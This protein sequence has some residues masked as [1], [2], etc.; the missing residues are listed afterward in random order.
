M[1]K[2]LKDN[3]NNMIMKGFNI[4]DFI[5]AN[6]RLSV[7]GT[8]RFLKKERFLPMAEEIET[9]EKVLDTSKVDFMG[10]FEKHNTALIV[11]KN[12]LGDVLS[13]KQGNLNDML[14][15][16][17]E[18]K[19]N[20][21]KIIMI[22]DNK[23][24]LNLITKS[25][26]CFAED[27]RANVDK[28]FDE[29]IWS[30]GFQAYSSNNGMDNARKIMENNNIEISCSNKEIGP[31]GIYVK[32]TCLCVSKSDLQSVVYEGKRAFTTDDTVELINNTEDYSDSFN[33]EAIVKNFEVVGIWV[34]SEFANE[35]M[36]NNL[37]EIL[38]TDNLEIL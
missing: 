29:Y 23:L 8:L 35:Q 13:Y 16:V 22:K 17:Y 14:D 21:M 15:M 24:Q 12:I 3:F 38:G 1:Y 37:V 25:K 28:K 36:I 34:K 31:F 20:L 27:C 30:H 5:E 11:L 10:L 33:C 4:N 19:D 26:V 6:S 2:S 32:G 7:M 18:E 9:I